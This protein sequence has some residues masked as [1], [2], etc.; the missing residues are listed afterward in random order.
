MAKTM[1]TAISI[2]KSDYDLLEKLRKETGKSRSQL[3]VE[4]FHETIKRREQ[5][6]I[7]RQYEEA[8]RRMPETKEELKGR[9]V[10]AKESFKVWDKEEW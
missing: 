4:A 1:K 8:Y 7:D 10:W 5:Q 6:Q 2:P 9:D 3:L